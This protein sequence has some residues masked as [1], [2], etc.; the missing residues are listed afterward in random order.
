MRQ[1]DIIP[2]ADDCTRYLYHCPRGTIAIDEYDDGVR[3]IVECLGYSG[4]TARRCRDRR[5]A[6]RL[7]E[8]HIREQADD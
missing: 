5:E 8:D 6:E 2:Q 1:G 7:H 3:E 4:T